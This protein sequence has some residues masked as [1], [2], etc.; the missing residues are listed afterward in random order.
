MKSIHER[1]GLEDAMVKQVSKSNRLCSCIAQCIE[2]WRRNHL[3]PGS[4]PA[5]HRFFLF[6]FCDNRFLFFFNF[7][8]GI[9]QL[10]TPQSAVDW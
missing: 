8:K 4:N 3:G 5:Q 1:T 6:I 10:D 9:R 2:S 7:P